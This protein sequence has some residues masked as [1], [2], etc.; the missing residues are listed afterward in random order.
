MKK[1][2]QY[3]ASIT[4]TGNSGEGTKDYKSYERSYNIAISNKVEI[5]GSSDPAFRGDQTKH[6]P[7]DLFLASVSSCHM[8]WYLHFCAVNNIVVTEY[9]DNAKGT[10]L[11][12]DSGGL[13]TEVVLY[14]SVVITDKDKIE[15]ASRL[16]E[17]ANK[18]CFIAN[19]LNFK[20]KHRPTCR[21]TDEK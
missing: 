15:L 3:S 1:E 10:M 18:H 6:N 16:H 7:E 5:K 21:V 19:S 17:E 14:P 4:W 9:I 20:V 12:T 8:L 13:F 11:E 2:H